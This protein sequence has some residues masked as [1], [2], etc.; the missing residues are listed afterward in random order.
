MQLISSTSAEQMAPASS[1]LPTSAPHRWA[2]LLSNVSWTFGGNI[3][4]L[5][6]QFGMLLALTRFTDLATVGRFA[7]ASAIVNP[8]MLLADMQ[9]RNL[10]IVD[11]GRRFTAWDYVS[12]RAISISIAISVIVAIAICHSIDVAAIILAMAVAKAID[13]LSD[14]FQGAMQQLEYFRACGISTTLRG[15]L[16]GA[17]SIF[18]IIYFRDLN[19]AILALVFAGSAITVAFDFPL[20]LRLSSHRGGDD[21]NSLFSNQ[22]RK[23]KSLSF[24]AFPLG[25]A[26]FLAAIEANLPR[27]FLSIYTSETALGV[28]STIVAFSSLGS[29]LITAMGQ[30][31]APRLAR[32]RHSGDI[33]RFRS[34]LSRLILIGATIGLVALVGAATF[35]KT[36]LNIVF[37]RDESAQLPLLLILLL[38]STFTYAHIFLG[39]ALTASGMNATKARIQLITACACAVFLLILTP[40]FGLFGA[41]ISVAATTALTGMIYASTWLRYSAKWSAATPQSTV[42]R[43]DKASAQAKHN[44][45]A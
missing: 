7:Y 10:Q 19:A 36:A 18:V 23:L 26:S 38:A 39:T 44:R 45:A 25:C 16:N 34:L 28:Y 6:A 42:L 14:V 12:F 17:C 5:T 33:S 11:V 3:V 37:G 15:V 22:L 27:Y 35:G 4:Q 41:A 20:W 40:W 32:L 1:F 2:S 9:L 13:S 24:A 21:T 29:I 30:S 8:I 31:A 43:S